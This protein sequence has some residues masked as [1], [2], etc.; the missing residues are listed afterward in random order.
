MWYNNNVPPKQHHRQVVRYKMEALM[1]RKVNVFVPIDLENS[2]KKSET[3]EDGKG[4]YVQGF[5]STPDLDL[6]NDIVSPN[7]IDISYFKE[8]G[9]INYEH[10]QDAEFIIGAPTEN[11]YVDFEKG[12]FVEA[13]LYADNSYAKAMWKLAHSIKKSGDD[14]CLGFSIEGAIVSRDTQDDRVITSLVVRNVALTT[15]PANPHAT[16]ETLV[17]SWTTGHGTSPETQTNAGALRKEEIVGAITTL[18]HVYA[19][20]DS[21]LIDKTWDDVSKYLAENEQ[22]DKQVAT[23]L[24]QLSRGISKQQATDFLNKER[25]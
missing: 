3:A 15:H 13:K 24:L 11:C 1:E 12:L 18:S 2:F 14:R 7:G 9:W 5:A 21:E 6:Q 23:I 22:V 20:T 8:Y 25:G 4:W 19:I 10:K 16:W 17:K